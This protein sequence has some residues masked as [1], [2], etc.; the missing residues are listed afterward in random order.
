MQTFRRS[1]VLSIALFVICGVGYPIAGWAFSEAAF[2]SQANGSITSNGSTLIGQPWGTVT[3]NGIAINPKWFNGRPDEDDPLSLTY[4][5]GQA[6]G[7]ESGQANFGPRS[8]QL[9][10][11][12]QQMLA[13]WRKVGVDDPTADLV[14]S[15]ASGLDPDL[16]PA[17]VLVQ[18]PMVAKAR[19]LSPAVLR[20][21][22]AHE[23]VGPQLGFLGQSYVN[24]LALNEALAKLAG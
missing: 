6:I 1:I 15:S 3:S 5:G 14:T 8:T 2:H 19:G 18:V 11:F 22:I 7:G 10:Q 17:D 16:T 4:P 23:T 21:L 13:A 12:V 20:E 9:V 24:V